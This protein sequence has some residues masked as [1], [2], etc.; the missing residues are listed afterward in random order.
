MRATALILAAALSL[1]ALAGAQMPDRQAAGEQPQPPSQPQTGSQAAPATPNVDV[2]RLGVSLDRIK[3][4]L[5]DNRQETAPADSAL[6]LAF[7]VQVVGQA[8]KIDLLQ[9]FSLTGPNQYGA[10]THHEILDVVTPQAYR[11]PM[12]PFSTVAYW[13]AQKIAQKTKKSRC[14]QE[15]ADY[16]ALLMSGVAVTAPTCSQ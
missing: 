14:E 12:I 6:K 16:E 8:P 9:G 1:P 3:R 2:S 13:A 10:P 7:T 11:S 4:Q 5:Q 15:I